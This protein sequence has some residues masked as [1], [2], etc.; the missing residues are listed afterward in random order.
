MVSGF[1]E[2]STRSNAG[3]CWAL[4]LEDALD[5]RPQALCRTSN[6]CTA[7]ADAQAKKKP[8]FSYMWLVLIVLPVAKG[9][10][11]AG[12]VGSTTGFGE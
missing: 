10:S 6:G 4:P 2:W 5:L 12:C 11:L 3:F 1:F 7:A 9:E 8:R